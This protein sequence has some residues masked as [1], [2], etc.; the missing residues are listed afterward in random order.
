MTVWAEYRLS[1]DWNNDGD[2]GESDENIT[3][4][5]E[6][7]W[8]DRGRDNSSQ[9]EGKSISGATEW[10]L[11]NSDGEFSSFNSGSPFYGKILPNR[12]CKIEMRIGVGAWV[13]KFLGYLEEISPSPAAVQ[14]SAKA[15][16]RAHGILGW[17][18]E[19]KV[20]VEMHTNIK[21]G[22]AIADVCT[23]A[24]IPSGKRT[25][26]T[27][28]S[29]IGRWWEER[30]TDAL[31]A[32]RRLEETEGGFI[33]EG[34]DG[35]F[36]FEDRA[37][38]LSHSPLATISNSL[39]ANIRYS[40][41]KQIDTSKGL[42]N[43]FTASVRTFDLTEGEVIL[44]TLAGAP[45]AITVQDT[46][47]LTAKFP[48]PQTASGCLAVDD[49]GIIDV[50]LNDQ[51]DGLGNDVADDFVIDV[52]K[53]ATELEISLHNDGSVTGYLTACQA[54]GTA[55][56]EGDATDIS[57][58]PT[59][60]VVAQS[61]LDYGELPYVLPGAFIES[62]P[63]A[64]AFCGHYA[65]VYC[66]L[67]PAVELELNAN[68]S[69]YHL[70]EAKDRDI[71]DI[72][73]IDADEDSGLYLDGNFFVER[74]RHEI[75][76]KFP[77]G[78]DCVHKVTYI[79]G[80]V[81]GHDWSDSTS[82]Y[83]PKEIPITPPG[84]DTATKVPDDL[85]PV[86][87]DPGGRVDVGIVAWKWNEGI[88][89]GEIRA[90]FYSAG[91]PDYVDLRTV[92]EG[93]TF[94]G[95]SST[96][97]IITGAANYAGMNASFI[98]DSYGRWYFAGRLKNPAGWS[99]WSDG[100]DK[101]T[102]VKDYVAIE[103]GVSS[104]G[105]P[106]NDSVV[107]L[108]MVG[109]GVVPHASRPAINGNTLLFGAVQIKNGNMG[110]WYD[111]DA[112]T[113]P[114]VTY[115]D[116]SAADHIYDKTTGRI[117]AP[118]PI[119][120][121]PSTGAMLMVDVRNNSVFH[122]DW[123]Q[124]GGIKASDI[125]GGN[126]FPASGF[127]MN[128]LADSG[129]QWQHVRIKI[130]KW[131]S[132]W[133]GYGYYGDTPGRG[134]SEAPEFWKENGD[135]TTKEFVFP[136]IP[137]DAAS[138]MAN[139]IGRVFFENKLCRAQC[140]ANSQ[141]PLEDTGSPA[142]ASGLQIITHTQDASIPVGMMKLTWYRDTLNYQ[143]IY[144]AGFWLS[145]DLPAQGPFSME[146]ADHGAYT[147]ETGTGAVVTAEDTHVAVTRGGTV[148]PEHAILVIFTADPNPDN[149]LDAEYVD[150]ADGTGFTMHTPFHKSGTYSYAVI[151]RWMDTGTS[152][153]ENLKYLQFK[154]PDE[155][156]GD[157][158]AIRWTTGSVPMP[159][160]VFYVT[161]CSRNSMG[162]GTRMTCSSL[163]PG[164]L[165]CIPLNIIAGTP[166]QIY[167]EIGESSTFF[168]DAS[169]SF[170]LMNPTGN[171]YC[172]K[173]IV[174]LI[175]QPLTG[176]PTDISEF[177]T[178]FRFGDEIAAVTLSAAPGALDYLGFIYFALEDRFDCVAC[179]HG[180]VG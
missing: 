87:F 69:S 49:W 66:V 74:L 111:P 123:C 54:R 127:R 68:K 170:K 34:Q 120:G 30:E 5:V 65:Q 17:L 135:K 143:S 169:V 178:K 89:E 90:K 23:Q 113:G 91:A 4:Y 85:Q 177:D 128:T 16:L 155:I 119:T 114:A 50:F 99:V 52:D 76:L 173:P 77:E 10:V 12:L 166:P 163:N 157:R 56:I 42:H 19:K 131:L 121:V 35:K 37:H 78:L 20:T 175:R 140:G 137:L 142:G 47:I 117:T 83:V 129:Q 172:G 164:G 141:T 61:L 40:K 51:I 108:E 11:D 96:E 160:G 60:S 53:T 154:V 44:W 162:V 28:R 15:T 153:S 32:V 14:T 176:G 36:I 124:W 72:V 9:L 55:V 133:T 71:S 24:G 2:F 59:I 122:H 93:G 144:T 98:S 118:G 79:C 26:D 100:N 21:T 132:E 62:I 80:F 29:T 75:L 134:I 126:S 105:G 67:I 168:I 145:N 138:P 39:T 82:S 70:T 81:C 22:A 107:T 46:L 97:K 116:G 73:H 88:T 104:D 64:K 7:A 45:P 31:T 150:S 86:G 27:G 3:S 101:P 1:V 102:K 112:N 63:E 167:T 103:S 84:G 110:D 43:K 180:Y 179:V 38:R 174:Y 149:D 136:L 139:I 94:V 8:W 109:N 106:P 158:E 41:I 6:S 161:G 146:R 95:G 165:G 152:E 92:A 58:D 115:Y 171:I 57:N 159:A 25:I 151:K 125:I 147:Y 156:G 148:I 18:A 13:T 130:V 48:S 33:R